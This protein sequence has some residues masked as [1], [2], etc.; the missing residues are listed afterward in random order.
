MGK[1][2]VMIGAITPAN[3]DRLV[4]FTQKAERNGLQVFRMLSWSKPITYVA[5]SSKQEA[6]AILKRLIRPAQKE[7]ETI[8]VMR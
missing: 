8:L 4:D 7:L 5:A 6:E 1:Q 2:T 3:L